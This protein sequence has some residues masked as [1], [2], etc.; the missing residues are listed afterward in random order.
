MHFMW[1]YGRYGSKWQC[2]MKKLEVTLA[3]N[4]KLAVTVLLCGKVPL[5]DHQYICL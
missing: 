3:L 5:Y 1:V 2:V 4:C